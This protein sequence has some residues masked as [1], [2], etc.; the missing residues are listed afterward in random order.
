MEEK[1]AL[2][3]TTIGPPNA[4]LR[5][6]ASGCL[7]HDIDFIIIGDQKSPPQFELE[8]CRFYHLKEQFELDFSFARKCPIGNYARKNVG[9]LLAIRSAASNLIET[10]DDNFPR[11]A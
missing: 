4:A 5:D 9:Y 6:L 2:V 8:G 1:T 3:V 11:R 10:D 7:K